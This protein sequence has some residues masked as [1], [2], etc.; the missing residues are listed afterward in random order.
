MAFITTQIHKLNLQTIQKH[1]E[2]IKSSALI[3][4]NVLRR[5]RVFVFL[6]RFASKPYLSEIVNV[7]TN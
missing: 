3:K 1:H 5:E 7:A 4:I 6:N 2:A